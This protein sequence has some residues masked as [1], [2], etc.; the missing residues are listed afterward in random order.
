M[1]FQAGHLDD[2]DHR[3]KYMWDVL[4]R[5]WC[6]SS[7]YP[8]VLCLCVGLVTLVCPED[9]Y[10]RVCPLMSSQKDSTVSSGISAVSLWCPGV[11]GVASRWLVWVILGVCIFLN[12]CGC[13][14]QSRAFCVFFL[15]SSYFANFCVPF[16]VDLFEFVFQCIRDYSVLF[17]TLIYDSEPCR[18]G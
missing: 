6:A 3:S 16:Y 1:K 9:L 17:G 2:L 10:P 13:V 15:F 7:V 5:W 11:W 18:S 8:G 14:V 4:L 12:A